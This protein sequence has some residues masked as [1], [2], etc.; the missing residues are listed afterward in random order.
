MDVRQL[1]Y[2]LA[3]V[4][5]DGFGRAA[6]YLRISQPSLSQSVASLEREL[7]VE[8]FHRVGR[9]ASLSAAGE[10]L[11]GHA[12]IVVR[13]IEAARSAMDSIRG[14]RSG[15]VDIS[16]MPSPGI[17]PLTSMIA[18][19]TTRHPEIAVAVDGAFS[20]D[21]VVT[22]VRTGTAEVGLLGA[23]SPPRVPGVR[24][25]PLGAQPLMLIVN[26]DDD[27]FG[28]RDAIP[29]EGL[30]GARL[31]V[32]HRGSLMR[33]LVDE[34]LSDGIAIE[35]AVE[36]AHRTSILPLVLRGIG[37]AVMP[38]S[39]AAIAAHSGLKAIRLEPEL[40]LHISVISRAEHLSAAASAFLEVAAEFALPANR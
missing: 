30:A 12:R 14:V 35:I 4:D 27:R 28:D 3:I 21:D 16:A 39:W 29:R 7:G 31:I 36:V 25:M 19:F 24:S 5:H 11:V 18:A 20:V 22:A 38:A 15:R 40:V 10:Q 6:E 23:A 26:P 37:H 33:S 1:R 2:F 8:L 9:R 34:M 13:D 17:E 32:S